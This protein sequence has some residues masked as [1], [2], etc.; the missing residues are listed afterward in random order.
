MSEKD[1]DVTPWS[2]QLLPE[3]MKVEKTSDPLP[4]EDEVQETAWKEKDLFMAYLGDACCYRLLSHKEE[5]IL[6]KQ[7]RE[8]RKRIRRMLS[9][10][11]GGVW[12]Q[13]QVSRRGSFNR[14]TLI[15]QREDRLV[16]WL[17]AHRVPGLSDRR[18][19]ALLNEIHAGEAMMQQAREKLILAN[20]KLVISIANQYRGL[21]LPLLDLIQEGNL[22]LMRA[23]ESFDPDKGYR[24]STYATSW[25]RQ[26][27]SR[28]ISDKAR[29]V[30][31]P[32]HV[33]EK[34]RRLARVAQTLAQEK[35]QKPTPEEV[36]RRASLPADR[37]ETLLGMACDTVSLQVPVGGEETELG[38]FFADFHETSPVKYV[39]EMEKKEEVDKALHTLTPRE[40]KIVRLRFGIGEGRD[41]TLDEIGKELS[42]TRERVRQI[43]R[44]ALKKLRSGGA[45][46]RLKSVVA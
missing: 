14:Y 9:R 25:I 27:I 35:G 33:V 43:E 17:K 28:A 45:K 4:D 11:P 44:D 32:I 6:V 8:G 20:L 40:E 21:G 34:Y 30:R 37:V 1:H 18:F 31:L 16:Q 26:G 41:H 22:G 39:E 36:G 29:V 46:E 7:I 19:K 15:R 5:I 42:V 12:D 38:D 24:F 23:V 3:E 2:D 13:V 10:L